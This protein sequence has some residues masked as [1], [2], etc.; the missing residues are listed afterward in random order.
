[1]LAKSYSDRRQNLP[2]VD[3]RF[4]FL[5]FKFSVFLAPRSHDRLQKKE[6]IP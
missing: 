2:E 3:F 4:D 6:E 5:D 1:M